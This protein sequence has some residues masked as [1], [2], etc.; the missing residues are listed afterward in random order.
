MRNN[1]YAVL[2]LGFLTA[3]TPLVL[4]AQPSSEAPPTS[5][6]APRIQFAT[7]TFEFGKVPVGTIVRA[8][9]VLTNVGTAPLEIKD[10][11]PGCGCTTAGAWDQW[12]EPGKTTTLALQLNTANFGGA[13]VKNATVSCNDPAQPITALLIK[14]EVWKPIDVQPSFVIFNSATDISSNAFRLVRVIN[15]TDEQ[16]TL[17]QPASNNPAFQPTLK[18]ISPGKEFELQ[19]AVTPPAAGGTLQGVITVNTS[20][21]NLPPITVTAMAIIPPPATVPN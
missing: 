13:I 14:G 11:R 2:G 18:T 6:A 9:F 7:N 16:I 15:N 3:L 10:V 21:T 17:G 19:I 20:A 8:N 5:V 4:C 12:V 1:Q